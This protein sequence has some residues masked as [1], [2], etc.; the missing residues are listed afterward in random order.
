[1][2]YKNP[3]F[4]NFCFGGLGGLQPGSPPPPAATPERK[5]WIH[6]VSRASEQE[7]EFHIQFGRLKNE[8]QQFFKYFGMSI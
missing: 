8:G 4:L 2:I 6:N 3:F 5:Y 1:M 7:G